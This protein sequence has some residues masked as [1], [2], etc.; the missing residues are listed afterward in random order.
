MKNTMKMSLAAALLMSVGTVSAQAEDGVNVLSDV[1]FSGELRPRYEY[2]DVD[3]GVD[4]GHS[5]TNRTNLNIKAKL[6]EVDGLT[7]TIELNSVNDFN[8]L[9]KKTSQNAAEADEAK[10]TQANV[11]YASGSTTAVVGRKTVNLDNQR[12]IGSVGWKQNFQTLDLASA[13]YKNDS[14]SVLAAYVYGVNAIADNGN[15]QPNIY[16]GIRANGT[17]IPAGG[18]GSGATNTALLNASYKV[19]D[20]L[21]VTAYSY[22]IGSVSDTYG[23]ALTGKVKAGD[24]G[25]SYRAEYATQA[26]ATLEVKDFGKGQNDSSYYNIDVSANMSGILAGVNY[27]VLGDD[28]NGGAFQT[29]MATKHK[30]NGFADQFLIT[31]GAG[32]QDLNL[33]VGYKAKGFG[34]AKAIYHTYD[35]DAGSVNYGSELDLLYKNKITAFKGVTGLLKGA[36]YSGGDAAGGKA[37]DVTKVWAMLDYKF[38]I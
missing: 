20:E 3:N 17:I 2:T 30:F 16:Y 9:D 29:P 21:K 13:A 18:T 31:P 23:L 32:L 7:A 11:A 6:L 24:I 34:V 14:L 10:M 8:S 1:K 38:S 4:A 36:F 26:D 27:E 33:M 37:T 28:E 25:V 5:I 22:M 15:G 35:S 12:F 19:M